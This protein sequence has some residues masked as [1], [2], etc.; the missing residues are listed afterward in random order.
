MKN[1]LFLSKI[2]DNP[3]RSGLVWENVFFDLK[4]VGSLLFLALFHII[5]LHAQN[6]FNGYGHFFQEPRGYVVAKT[7]E[8]M[9]IDG[10]ADETSWDFAPWSDDFVDIEG[11]K[12]PLPQ[13]RTRMKLLW[14]D[15]CL[16]IFTEMEEPHIWAYF[17]KR[18]QIVYHEND[19]EVFLDPDGDTH[20]YFEFEVNARN[21]IFDLF[22]TRPYW[23]G[24]VPLISWN[25]PGFISAVDM[26]GTL[27]NPS[28]TD[29]KWT[30]EMAIPFSCLAL[31]LRDATPTEGQIWKANFSRVQWKTKVENGKYIKLAD[32]KTGLPLS[33]DNWVWSPT[34][35]IN[36]HVPERWGMLQFSGQPENTG[37]PSFTAPSDE[38][39]KKFLWLVYY[40]QETQK[41]ETGKYALTLAEIGMP[42]N[43]KHELGQE[44][45]LG[46]E[47][48]TMQ[49]TAF[50]IT[51][52]GKVFSI[53][54]QGYITEIKTKEK[55]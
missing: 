42:E 53:N 44:H 11:D 50:L 25:A 30:V 26:D 1:D 19:F 14:D 41:A 3:S 15:T 21:T 34:G 54:N 40:K 9:T 33:E 52:E 55:P 20:N 36:L 6:L 29:K 32:E 2:F 27:N 28:D 16:Y 49:F 43:L 46:M 12:K 24:G 48:T 38:S 17:D 22:L 39:L 35:E 37:L 31:G 47:A 7:S 4:R 18:D 45:K 23:D 10:K 51:L 13:F 8:Q 5:T